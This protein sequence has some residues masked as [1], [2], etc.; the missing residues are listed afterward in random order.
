MVSEE[1]E[2]ERERWRTTKRLNER[3]NV[4]KGKEQIY[5]KRTREKERKTG[6]K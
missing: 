6:R 3:L 1:R 4:K 5:G 2:R